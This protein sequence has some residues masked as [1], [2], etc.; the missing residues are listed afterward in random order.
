[1]SGAGRPDDTLSVPWRVLVDAALPFLP[2]QAV[3]FTA[4][5]VMATDLRESGMLQPFPEDRADVCAAW[6]QELASGLLFACLP[7]WRLVGRHSLPE[8]RPWL[9]REVEVVVA[10]PK[11]GW[12]K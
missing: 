5:E 6:P 8:N 7:A 4:D 10:R 3:L 9:E 1:M 11:G 2:E 12:N